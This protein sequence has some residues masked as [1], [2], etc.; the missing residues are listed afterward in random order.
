MFKGP[1]SQ[2]SAEGEMDP[3][4]H[5]KQYILVWVHN[6]SHESILEASTRIY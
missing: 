3:Q 4:S 6:S 2:H 5:L 1:F